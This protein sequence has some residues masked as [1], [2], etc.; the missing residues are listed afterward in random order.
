MKQ[1][2][3]KNPCKGQCYDIN[4][5]KSL[6]LGCGRTLI[7]IEKWSGMSEEEKLKITKRIAATAARTPNISSE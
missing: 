1:K 7:E 5:K 6:C 2:R 3:I 4:Y